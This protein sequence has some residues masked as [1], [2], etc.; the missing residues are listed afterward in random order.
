L[1]VWLD[2]P[3]N[4]NPDPPPKNGIQEMLYE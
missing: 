2:K 1:N 4:D 3:F